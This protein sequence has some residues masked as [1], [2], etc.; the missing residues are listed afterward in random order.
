MATQTYSEKLQHPL[1]QKKRL[2]ILNRDKFSCVLC[3]DKETT[4]HIHHK[5]YLRGKEPWDCDNDN[6]ETLCKH[7]HSVVEFFKLKNELVVYISKVSYE[8]DYQCLEVVTKPGIYRERVLYKLYINDGEISISVRV[9]EVHLSDL[10]KLIEKTD[11]LK[12]VELPF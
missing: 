9:N 12:S 1:W 11:H 4:L 10:L 2:E 3:G 8:Q 6:L 5:S 7:C